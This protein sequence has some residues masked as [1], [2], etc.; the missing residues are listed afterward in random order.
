MSNKAKQN[1]QPPGYWTKA[2]KGSI[3]GR[4][5]DFNA[6][7]ADP[8]RRQKRIRRYLHVFLHLACEDREFVEQIIAAEKGQPSFKRLGIAEDFSLSHWQV[9]RLLHLIHW[10]QPRMRNWYEGACHPKPS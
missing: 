4:S 2:F 8:A 3:N 6:D 1:V 5:L 7:N 9:M 10:L